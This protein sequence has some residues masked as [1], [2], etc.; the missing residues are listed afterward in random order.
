VRVSF[1]A[2]VLGTVDV[3]ED[4]EVTNL[5]V[6]VRDASNVVSLTELDGTEVPVPQPPDDQRPLLGKGVTFLSKTIEVG[7]QQLATE[8]GGEVTKT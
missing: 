6:D 3:D 7:L 2:L 5:T 1:L 4:G 8:T